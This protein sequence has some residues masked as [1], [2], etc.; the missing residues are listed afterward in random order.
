MNKIR[1]INRNFSIY[2]FFKQNEIFKLV[3]KSF[4]VGYKNFFFSKYFFIK[5]LNLLKNIKYSLS[6]IYKICLFTGRT[7]SVY[8]LFRISR[9]N[10][11]LE[12]SFGLI[13]GLK[14]SS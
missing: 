4:I 8:N 1:K 11:K 13:L 14:K 2:F 7:R 10:F 9:I 6:Y 12:S 5:K 3:L